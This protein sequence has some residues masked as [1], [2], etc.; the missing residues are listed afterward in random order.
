MRFLDHTQRRSTVGRT[1]LDE[2]SVRRRDLYL[3]THNTHTR[4]TYVSSAGFEPAIPESKRPWTHALDRITTG[5]QNTNTNNNNNNNGTALAQWLRC[6]AANRKVALSIPAG[7]SGIFHWNKILPIALWSWGRLSL[8][9]K[10]VLGVVPGD[11][12]GLCVRLTTYHHPVPLSRSLGTLTS[13]NPLSPSR[14]VMG[15]L[16]L[17]DDNNN[18][19]NNNFPE[20]LKLTPIGYEL[21]HST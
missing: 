15:L 3:T 5:I 7:F 14:P 18:N 21:S 16:Y 1:R 19:N 12:G 4:Q 8:Q 20:L 17:H 6:C 2:W 10:W 11:K 13:W 9:Q